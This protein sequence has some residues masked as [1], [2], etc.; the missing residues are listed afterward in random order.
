MIQRLQMQY[1]SKCK[2]PNERGK[3]NDLERVFKPLL[4]SKAKPLLPK[5]FGKFKCTM[6]S[7]ITKKSAKCLDASSPVVLNQGGI[8]H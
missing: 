2:V 8:L 5:Q 7:E 6:R 4:R 1:V 3:G